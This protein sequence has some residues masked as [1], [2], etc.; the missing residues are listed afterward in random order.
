MARDLRRSLAEVGPWGSRRSMGSDLTMTRK[1]P[2]VGRILIAEDREDT[3]TAL[4]ILLKNGGF[5]LEQAMSPTGALRKL[6]SNS[7]D[8]VLMDLNYSRDTTSGQEG[9]DLLSRIRSSDE[10]TSIVVMTAWS[11]VELAVQAMRRGANDFI[12]KPWDNERLL[13]ILG[14]QV[15][16]VRSRREARRLAAENHLLRGE[17]DFIAESQAMQPVLE[18][19]Q[20]VGPSEQPVLI[21]GESGAGKGVVARLLHAASPRADRA[22]VAVNVGGLSATIFE[23]ELFGHEAGA[24]TDARTERIGRFELADG[25]TLFLDEIA[26]VP[27]D[28]QAK[29][30][31]VVE[32]GEYERVGS[33]KRRRTDVRLISATNADI[34]TAIV[35]GRFRQDLYFRLNAIE[36]HVP[37]LRDRPEDIRPLAE[38]MLQRHAARYRNDLQQ[39]SEQAFQA[40][41][42]YPWPG[43]VREL[44]HTIARAVLVAKTSVIQPDDLGL[45]RF[46]SGLPLERMTLE[47][48]E[49]FVIDRALARRG[50]NVHRA[51]SDLGL[52]RSAMYRRLEKFGL[53]GNEPCE[54]DEDDAEA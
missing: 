44:N 1:G 5:E 9:L 32:T 16:L 54:P 6:S 31:H 35:E 40:L 38:F 51:A 8:V 33:S 42:E 49:R 7:Y 23:S 22:F 4:R 50:G 37:P 27:R 47:E 20:R 19:I 36:L 17:I 34:K 15:E 30:L 10:L 28:L 39:I 18:I 25:G 26:N 46:E 45:R 52:S 21:T 14:T 13:S 24:F 48:V 53:R 11:S 29:L 41:V 3:L 12:E 43:N 2:D